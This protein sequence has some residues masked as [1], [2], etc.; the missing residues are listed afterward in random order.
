MNKHE[1]LFP[2][3]KLWRRPV[4]KLKTETR[5][6]CKG[7]A[8]GV[9]FDIWSWQSERWKMCVRSII[10]QIHNMML[11]SLFPFSF[12]NL[13]WCVRCFLCSFRHFLPSVFNQSAV[14]K[15]VKAGEDMRYIPPYLPE[16]QTHIWALLPRWRGTRVHQATASTPRS[17]R[18]SGR[19]T[20]RGKN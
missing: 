1:A 5:S 2:A 8:D 10:L 7:N 13:W 3:E 9:R 16:H 20:G 17:Q 14:W 11:H 15:C 18:T 6:R 12:L 19:K 4:L